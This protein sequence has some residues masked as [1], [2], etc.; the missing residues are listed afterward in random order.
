MP[1]E[2]KEKEASFKL[3]SLHE[4]LT[5]GL[6]DGHD[7]DQGCKLTCFWGRREMDVG[8][9]V[10][11]SLERAQPHRPRAATACELQLWAV[12]DVGLPEGTQQI[13]H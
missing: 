10:G 12:Q 8:R 5:V 11:R 9:Q 3:T 4:N 2:R 13:S 1:S 7:L 6:D